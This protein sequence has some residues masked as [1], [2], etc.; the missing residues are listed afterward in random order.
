MTLLVGTWDTPCNAFFSCISIACYAAGF[1]Y[2]V[3]PAESRPDSL[4]MIYTY[5]ATFIRNAYP[6]FHNQ[7]QAIVDTVRTTLEPHTPALLAQTTAAG[8][9]AA[10]NA[11]F[12][13][14]MFRS[15]IAC[16]LLAA[17]VESCYDLCGFA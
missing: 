11:L 13:E 15:Q 5:A 17:G 14:R 10:M 3:M 9:S 16:L 2:Y 1:T 4:Y 6:V 7:Q 12:N 8:L